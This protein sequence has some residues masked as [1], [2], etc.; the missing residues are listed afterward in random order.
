MRQSMLTDEQARFLREEKETLSEIRLALT[1]IDVPREALT[2]TTSPGRNA[3]SSGPG[4]V[5]SSSAWPTR[6]GW[7]PY[8]RM[9]AMI[10]A[11]AYIQIFS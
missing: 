4:R 6:P 2:S 8:V 1:E 9:A 11:A 10:T 3:G 7:M 5:T